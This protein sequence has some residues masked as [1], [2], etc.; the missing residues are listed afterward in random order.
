MNDNNCMCGLLI[1]AQSGK[2]KERGH[3][4]DDVE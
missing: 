3:N 2:N 1:C 4:K